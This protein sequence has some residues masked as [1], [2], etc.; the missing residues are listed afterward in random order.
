MKR[1]VAIAAVAA[2]MLVAACGSDEK[3]DTTN[4]TAAPAESTAPGETAAPGD[5]AAAGDCTLTEPLKIGYA[6]DFDLGGI[7]DVPATAAAKFIIDQVNAAGGVGGLPVEYEVKQISQNPQDFPAAQRG[8]Q[9]LLDGGADII[10]GPPFSDYGLPL[11]EVT[12]GEV[13]VLFV[14]S[15]EVT[16]SDPS[17]GSFLVSFNDRVQ[18][19]AAAEFSTKKGFTTAVTISSTDIPYLNVTTSAFKEV[20]EKAGGKVSEDFAYNLGDTDFSAQ[21]NAIAAMSPQP[22]VVYSAFFL[23]EAG[24]FLKQLR[25]AGVKSAVISADGF[26]ASLIWTVGADAEGVFFTSHTF[27]GGNNNVQ[28]FLDEYAKS[29]NPPIETVAFGALGADAAQIA[30]AAAQAACSTDGKALIAA[31]EGLTVEVT[32]GTTSYEGAG[33]TP[34]RNVSILTVTN[35]APALADEFYPTVVAEG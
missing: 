29:D 26:D 7:G 15:T 3:A 28:A 8:V 14:T 32:T 33:G 19:S 23:P 6:A 5:T 30:I 12:K 27:P 9:E 4:S 2:S 20:F 13:P 34:K 35:G 11:L 22:D 17:Q 31:I 18:A 24:V 16:L 1:Q 21:V 10:L 25:E